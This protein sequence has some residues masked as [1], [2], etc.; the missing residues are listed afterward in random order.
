R[1]RHPTK[2]AALHLRASEAFQ[3]YN[4]LGEAVRHASLAGDY[5]RCTQLIESAG[6]WRLV[7]YGGMSQLNQLLNYIPKAERLSHPRLLL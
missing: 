4:I 3:Q 5:S 6:G 2:L 1:Q 7:L